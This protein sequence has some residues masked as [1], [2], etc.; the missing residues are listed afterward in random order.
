MYNGVAYP[1]FDKVSSE[2]IDSVIKT[3]LLDIGR[4]DEKVL[5]HAGIASEILMTL[6]TLEAASVD[7]LLS[8]KQENQVPL[9]N[10]RKAIYDFS[11]EIQSLPWDTNFQY[12]CLQLYNTQV[13]PRVQ[14]I[15]E[16]L[17][18]TSVLKN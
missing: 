6:P 15:N 8:L 13:I 5:R 9:T 3:R 12:D 10:F 4:L 1:L 17:T 2:L 14:E 18:Q 11:G 7:E 16:V